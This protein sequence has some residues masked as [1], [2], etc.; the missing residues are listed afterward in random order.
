M[1]PTKSKKRV[2][3]KLH[4]HEWPVYPIK[5]RDTTI[6]R[7]FHRVNGERKPKTFMSMADAKAD[8]KNILKE[9]Y[10]RADSKIHLT[11]DDKRDWQA[12]MNLIKEAGLRC[13]L[14]T[15]VRHHVDLV[16]IVGHESLLTDVVRKHAES[17]GKTGT[18][19]KLAVLRESY[20]DALK[21]RGRSIRYQ[22]T[23][24][25]HTGQLLKHAPDVMSDQVPRELIQEFID[26]KKGCDARTKK[27]LLDAVEAMM[28]FGQSN[29]SVPVEWDEARHV[30]A[31]AVTPKK[32]R[33]YTAEELI[34]LLVAAPKNYRHILALAAF[35]G[36]RSSE[37]ELLDWKHIRMF[38]NAGDRIIKL[39]VDVTEE[40]SKRSIPIDD[41]LKLWLT[42][43]FKWEG[44][45]WKG[46]HDEFYLMQQTIA[47]KAGVTWQQNALRHTC[48]SAKIALTKNVPQVALESGNSV[49][50]IKKHYL[51]LMTP[52]VAKAWFS[53]TRKVVDEEESRML[54]EAAAKLN[55]PV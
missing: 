4:G 43:P 53:V 50:M 17:R 20:M 39:D 41:H 55:Q 36:I 12:A 24:R 38:E 18:P 6:Y 14:E 52:S 8:A 21:K 26:S 11:E 48:I 29:R 30:V 33:T 1:N 44:K 7:V 34:K 51:D 9:I 5:S 47:E 27:N 15:L 25:S 32:V 31:P 46:T 42:R 13:G 16:K 35:T 45:L 10:G 3:V 22:Q 40:S 28:R 19:V 37:L 23:Q 2:V 49:A 54:A